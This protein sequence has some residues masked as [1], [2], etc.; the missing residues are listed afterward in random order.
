MARPSTDPELRAMSTVLGI[1]GELTT[2]QRG[3]VMDWVV[4]RI[5]DDEEFGL[6]A[7]PEDPQEQLPLEADDPSSPTA[8]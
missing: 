3:R 5:E 8:A 7:I 1:L 6:G 4:S 2:R